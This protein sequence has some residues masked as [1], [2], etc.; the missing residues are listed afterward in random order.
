[1]KFLQISSMLTA[2]LVCSAAVTERQMTQIDRLTGAKGTY[3]KD[4]GVYKVAFPR[5]DVQV[6][7]DRRPM[8]P[9]MG[10]TS[11]AA[12]TSAR[13]GQVMGD[14]ALLKDEVNPVMSAALDNG[15]E[16]TALHNHFFFDKPKVM[17]MHIAGTGSVEQLADAVRKAIDTMHSVRRAAPAPA[18]HFSGPPVPE[19]SSITPGPID[20]ILGVK[21]QANN[22]MY[23]VVIGRKAR[24]HGQEIGKQM[25]VNTWAAFAGSDENASV[26]GDFAMTSSEVQKVLKALRK[27]GINIVALHNHMIGEEPQFIFLHYWG[28]GKAA[29][30]AKSL[31]AALEVQAK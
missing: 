29:E 22:G 23:K 27:A 15:L 16:V 5:H 14:F 8:H 4:E 9:F 26:D 24:A 1:M 20:S 25:G 3:A 2:S 12:F 19:R 31:K 30:L 6:S 21:G 18:S 17:F 10:I 7:V 13:G 11:W 28:K